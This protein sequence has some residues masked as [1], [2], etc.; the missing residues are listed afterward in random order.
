MINIK[1]EQFTGPLSL[2]LKI[3][4]KEEMDITEVSLAKIA[5]QYVLYIRNSDVISPQEMADFLVVAAKLLYIKSKALLPYLILEEEEEDIEELE[6]QLK[7]YKEFLEATKKIEAIVGKKK[8]MFPREFNRKTILNSVK[9]FAPPKKITGYDIKDVFQGLIER[10]RPAK[11]ELEEEKIEHTVSIE[12]KI[13]TIQNMLLEK[14]R[15]N[16]MKVVNDASSKTEVIVS[17]L[18]LLELSKQKHLLIEQD[19]LFHDIHV[20]KHTENHS[21]GQVFQ[22]VKE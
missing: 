3:I 2:L 17:F 1:T 18:A 4:E 9:L 13:M 11:Q 10:V 6:R 16:F 19:G 14:I 20:N 22:N 5:D 8:F 7:M 12:D 15:F 21:S